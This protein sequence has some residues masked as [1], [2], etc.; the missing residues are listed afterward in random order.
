MYALVIV[1]LLYF[2]PYIGTGFGVSGVKVNGISLKI[3]GYPDAP[4]G[5]D[6][7]TLFKYFVP[8]FA[9]AVNG[10]PNGNHKFNIHAF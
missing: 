8:V 7:K 1:I 10:R 3:H 6:Q 5:T 2:S 4:F 9:A